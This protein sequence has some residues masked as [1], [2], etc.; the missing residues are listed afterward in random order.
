MSNFNFYDSTFDEHI[1]NHTHDNHKKIVEFLT[2]LAICHTVIIQKKLKK[3]GTRQEID[4]DDLE[5]G[6]GKDSYSA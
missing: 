3:R 4:D 5:N 1:A 2:H 6:Q